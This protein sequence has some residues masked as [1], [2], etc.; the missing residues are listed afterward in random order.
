MSIF[1]ATPY[2]SFNNIVCLVLSPP[3]FLSCLT[4][5]LFYSP[6]PAANCSVQFV[7]RKNVPH[8][9]INLKVIIFFPNLFLCFE[10]A[11][12]ILFAYP[13]RKKKKK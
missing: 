5:A 4:G 8:S 11:G 6:R 3:S 2:P 13:V 7:L 9:I 1:P 12:Q 10:F